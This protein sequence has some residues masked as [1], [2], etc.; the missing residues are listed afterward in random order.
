MIRV[1]SF[2]RETMTHLQ[3]VAKRPKLIVEIAIVIACKLL[4]IF[5]LWYFFFSPEHRPAVTP[6]TVGS[7]ILGEEDV[8]RHS[9]ETQSNH[10]RSPQ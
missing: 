7:A 8:L 1:Q 9:P 3:T 10:I 4:F 6:E 5:G 2:S